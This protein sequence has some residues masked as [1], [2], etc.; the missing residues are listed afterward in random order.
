MEPSYER[1]SDLTDTAA[2]RFARSYALRCP[3]PSFSRLFARRTNPFKRYAS[4]ARR[5][6]EDRPS[7]P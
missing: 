1:E 5:S 6:A 2:A 4:D 3:F 7:S